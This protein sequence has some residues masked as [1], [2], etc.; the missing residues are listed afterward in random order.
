MENK[1]ILVIGGTGYIGQEILKK[2]SQEK[3]KVSC[4]V[5]KKSNRCFNFEQIKGDVLDKSS[6]IM[7]TKNKDLVVY[8]AAIRKGSRKKCFN[9]NVIGL[10]N[11]LE[12]METNRVKK[13]IYF[14]TKD[15]GL[16]VLDNYGETKKLAEKT[17]SKYNIEAAILRPDVVYGID[18]ENN[19]FKLLKITKRYHILPIFGK[20]DKSFYPVNKEFV[21]KICV[22]LI[23]NFEPGTHGISGQKTS[24]SEIA[25]HI[26]SFSKSSFLVIHIPLLVGEI[27]ESMFPFNLSIFREDRPGAEL[28]FSS[29]LE[30]K[31]ELKEISEL[32][33]PSLKAK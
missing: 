1:R 28:D 13:I 8:L 3:I 20:G 4:L 31:S 25:E 19:F 7:A 9:V 15:V 33:S 6:L 2:L 29:K 14:S 11:T 10:K 27:L 18:K 30:L 24:F 26:K 16:K 23:K 32:V 17:L 5:R 21:S 22:D 12:A